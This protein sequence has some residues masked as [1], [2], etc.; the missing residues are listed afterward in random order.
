MKAKAIA[1]S[2]FLLVSVSLF[3]QENET[4][5]F[6]YSNIT[7]F[8]FI[9]TNPQ[10][11]AF[12]GTTVQGFSMNKQHCVG[13][14]IGMGGCSDI[15]FYTP[16][17]VNYRYYFSPKKSFSPQVNASLGGVLVEDGEGIYSSLT[18]G[19][20]AGKFSFSSGFSFMAVYQDYYY[21][22]D[23]WGDEYYKPHGSWEFPL[24]IT[25]KCG[26]TF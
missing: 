5:A 4:S 13:L 15:G 21:Y 1:F 10:R 22:N 23:R 2:A 7:E 16:I 26:F 20:K 3:S 8:G 6:K 25:I 18:V 12:E 19:F 24:G 11:V 14:G 9:T 17:F